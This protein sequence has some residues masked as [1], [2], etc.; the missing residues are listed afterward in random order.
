M[1]NTYKLFCLNCINTA[2]KNYQTTGALS[3][4][5]TSQELMIKNNISKRTLF[6]I[7][8]FIK[9][10][11]PD[12]F[13]EVEHG[14]AK[15]DDIDSNRYDKSTFVISIN[16][17][18]IPKSFL[19]K[20]NIIVAEEIEKTVEK[21][22]YDGTNKISSVINNRT[23]EPD[24]YVCFQAGVQKK[25]PGS[26]KKEAHNNKD[27]II[28]RNK[29]IDAKSEELAELDGN[30]Q[31]NPQAFLQT[32]NSEYLESEQSS[33]SSKSLKNSIKDFIDALP[34]PTNVTVEDASRG[35]KDISERKNKI[36]ITN[37]FNAI[38]PKKTV[39]HSKTS[40]DKQ[41]K[42]LRHFYPLLSKDVD[43][44]NFRTNREFSNNFVNQ[45]LLKLY[46]KYPEKS[47]KNKFTFLDYMVKAL[48][49]EKHQGPLVNHTTFRFSCNINAEEKNLLEYEKY[50]IQIENSFDT[51]KEMLV[52]KKIAGRFGTKTA[53]EILTQVE[54]KTNAHNILITAL[55]PSSLA[56]S[57]R[58]IEILSQQLEAVYGVNSSYVEIVED[59]EEVDVED[60][61]ER[62]EV[63]EETS[64]NSAEDKHT[65][66]KE[67]RNIKTFSKIPTGVPL[68]AIPTNTVWHQIRAE[69]IEELG[70]AIYTA[71][72]S[73]AV[74][75]ECKE[76]STLTLTMP[77]K[78]MADWI[79]SRYGY[80]ISRISGVL[81]FKF[82]EYTD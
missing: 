21:V 32:S 15:S 23:K 54:F 63:G 60:V 75:V 39:S 38:I 44:L 29:N 68:R 66:I 40:N 72:F 71:W 41:N 22:K 1:S 26:A 33:L 46:I 20:N 10:Q 77:T 27:I 61:Q 37:N 6:N 51:S 13:I 50:L 12:Y 14:Y 8:D 18:V 47:F 2:Y 45:L 43:T 5:A 55:I 16:P 69:L 17:I 7:F 64:N 42:E 70:E 31:I 62:L 11:Y 24:T 53:Y 80:A 73:K 48:K 79:K 28:K 67:L 81:G 74:A 65:K 30:N 78:F 34:Y 3:F 9:N 35:I 19:N 25:K 59:E 4:S 52:K 57:E 58:Q 56:L 49:N 36:N 82:I 76:T